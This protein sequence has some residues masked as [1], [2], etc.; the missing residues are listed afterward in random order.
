MNHKPLTEYLLKDL[1]IMRRGIKLETI[2]LLIDSICNDCVFEA[3]AYRDT[4]DEVKEL[5]E[6]GKYGTN[7]EE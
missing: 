6:R 5:M 7:T 3:E 1:F 4:Q 2:T